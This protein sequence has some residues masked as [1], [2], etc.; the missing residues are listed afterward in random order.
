MESMV[1][2]QLLNEFKG[3]KV[4]ITGH[5]GFKGS[6]L[7]YWLRNLGAKVKGYSLPPE[8]GTALF[9]H[10]QLP[11]SMTVFADINLSEVLSKEI[12]EFAPD[13]VFHLAAQPLVRRSYR[14]PLLTFQTNA[15]GTANVLEAIRQLENKC[16][17]VL[18]TTDKVY[19]NNEWGYPYREIDRLGGFD[20][21][22]ASKACAE[23]VISSYRSSYFEPSAYSAHNKAIASA[24]AGNVIGGGDWSEDRLI[25]D[26]IRALSA[27]QEVLIRN[28]HAVRPWQHV[29]E[30]LFGYL[31]LAILLNGNVAKYS[32]AW[33]FGP[34]NE[35]NLSVLEVA[36]YALGI[37]GAG[38][39]KT[40]SDANAPHE[41]RLLKLDINKVM[42]E[43][44]W[45]PKMNARTAIER[46]IS[47][48]RRY[49]NGEDAL[50]LM[51]DD[52]KYYQ[53]LFN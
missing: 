11:E 42:N 5:S 25:P 30:P 23:L 1:G 2:L 35:D 33:N 16:T 14:S 20:P 34:I 24:R 9:H 40:A 29:I 36:N 53:S 6:W 46:T 26:I 49:Y 45:K 51:D 31:V 47:W 22:S 39:L 41:A 27:E 32:G 18:I 38:S 43:V 48:Y 19:Q 4:F 21:Y 50:K 28:P 8:S 10:L 17:C 44:G 7:T 15:I 12:L 52:I 13:Y 37:W 3:K